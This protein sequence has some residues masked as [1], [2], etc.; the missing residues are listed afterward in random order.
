MR[1][2]ILAF[3]AAGA[4][5]LTFGALH[6]QQGGP[7]PALGTHDASKVA[8]GTYKA[9][10]NHTQVLYTYGHLGLTSNMGL[11]SGANGTL[12]LDPK[13]PNNAK[14]S[15]DVPVNTIHTSI[16]ALDSELVGPMFFDAA[17][18]PNAHF[19]STSVVA[20]GESATI[21]GNLT[22]HGVTKPATIN[23]KFAA[24]GTNPMSKKETIAFSGTATVNR[25]DFGLGTAVP[26]VANK[27]DLTI[28]AAFEKQ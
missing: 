15:I 23:A 19:E 12:T 17:K 3:T 7:P 10:P 28:T 2:S 8:A 11:L 24:A 4:A 6:A 20:K 22:I 5:A 16:A 9:D 21:N 26:M 18:F 25:A 1:K 13:A 14:L 27:V